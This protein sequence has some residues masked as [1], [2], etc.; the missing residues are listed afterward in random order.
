ML[1]PVA[2]DSRVHILDKGYVWLLGKGDNASIKGVVNGN[3]T[4]S[5]KVDE[6]SYY[7]TK[8]FNCKWPSPN[9]KI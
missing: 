8:D 9:F 4:I 7:H 3:A 2:L 1:E 6:S 5:D